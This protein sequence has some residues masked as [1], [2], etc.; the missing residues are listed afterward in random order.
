MIGL[1]IS[2]PF[3]LQKCSYCNFASGVFSQ[4]LL[5]SYLRALEDEIRGREILS[6]VDSIYFGGGTPSLLE[7]SQLERL[8]DAIGPLERAE[9]TME[10]SPLTLT[11]EKA[12]GWVRLG[13]TRV[14]LGVQS[15]VQ[16]EAAASGRRH[17]AADV[18]RE[19][20]VLRSSGIDDINVDLIAG[21]AHQTEAGWEE[22]LDWV[23]RL[24]PSH[25]SVYM[26]E[27]DDESLLGQEVRRGGNRFGADRAPS[28]DQI[29]ACYERAV[30]RLAGMGI[31]R[32]EIS[33]FAARGHLSRHNLK[34]WNMQPYLGFGADAH[35]F[36]EGKR[37][38]N[39]KTAAEYVER[40]GR[41]ESPRRGEWAI[42]PER[43]SEDKFITGLRQMA[44]VEP[45]ESEW[46]RYGEVLSR[47]C[48]R[49]WLAKTE[50]G[51]ARLTSE[52]VMF[53]NEV[54]QQFLKDEP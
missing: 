35:S 6:S 11:A 23:E 20:A 9:V 19:M 51:R 53:S 26:L 54:F 7:P 46:D 3:C 1:Y 52:G 17:T 29:A 41:G 28:E 5:D 47:L 25:V 40:T 15:F 37:W 18:A 31:H 4:P 10:A 44:G 22:S 48:K 34:Y 38:A 39:A 45:T 12:R 27:V 14:S 36:H 42:S 16:R 13:T 24:Q 43:R 50:N 21:L 49:G 32:Y 30:E 33:N 2:I 8:F